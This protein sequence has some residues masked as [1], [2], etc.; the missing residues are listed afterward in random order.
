MAIRM[1]ARNLVDC[2]TLTVSSSAVGLDDATP[3]LSDFGSKVKRVMISC[4][5]DAVRYRAD[6]TAPTATVGHPLAAAATLILMDSNYE[7]VLQNLQFIRQSGDATLF[8][9]YF[10]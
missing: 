3:P 2:A 7:S 6:G 8:I 1:E 5:T 9:S 4:N 10:D